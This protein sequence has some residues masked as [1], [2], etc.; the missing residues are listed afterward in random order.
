MFSFDGD[1]TEVPAQLTEA[2]LKA[3]Q[4]QDL[5]AQEFKVGRIGKGIED[6]SHAIPSEGNVHNYSGIFLTFHPPPMFIRRF[7]Q[8]GYMFSHKTCVAEISSQPQYYPMSIV[9]DQHR[10]SYNT[11]HVF[12]P[13]VRVYIPGWEENGAAIGVG[14][15]TAFTEDGF[16]YLDKPMKHSMHV[17]R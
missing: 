5:I 16:Q 3:N 8:G 17:V 9:S 6:A 14:R 12:H 15:I 1:E 4:L 7:L 11:V 2:L 13:H 10:L